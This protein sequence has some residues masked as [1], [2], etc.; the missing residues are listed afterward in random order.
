MKT[1]LLLVLTIF[2]FV[3]T[4]FGGYGDYGVSPAIKIVNDFYMGL[5]NELGL[6]RT[7]LHMCFNEKT[8]TVFIAILYKLGTYE[9]ALEI[10]NFTE[11][12]IQGEYI[13]TFKQHLNVTFAC[14]SESTDF[15]NIKKVLNFTVDPEDPEYNF[16]QVPLL[17]TP[18]FQAQLSNW[19]NYLYQFMNLRY[20]V[21][22]YTGGQIYAKML[23]AVFQNKEH[24]RSNT[25]AL[26]LYMTGI[27]KNFNLPEPNDI[28][29][30]FNQTTS[31]S[32]M[33]FYYEWTASVYNIPTDM[34]PAVTLHFYDNK[35][36][37][38]FDKIPANVS[39]CVMGTKSQSRLKSILRVDPHG[40][41]F[42]NSFVS[43]VH[44]EPELY[45]SYFRPLHEKLRKGDIEEAGMLYGK[46]METIAAFLKGKPYK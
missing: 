22:F 46:F 7:D 42:F 33:A 16:P 35:A 1:P 38:I 10:A 17:I 19:R 32:E 28:I 30:C 39:Y 37:D 25:R 4:S 2:L 11:L 20:N 5:M 43:F 8:A 31:I 26:K 36:K 27:F 29:S 41:E 14:I 18:Y 34:V 12:K 24:L 40:S 45:L 15:Q 13:R 21:K 6:F 23:K 44:K 3:F 9:E